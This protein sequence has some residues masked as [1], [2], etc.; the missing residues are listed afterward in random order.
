MRGKLHIKD[1][2]K[3]WVKRGKFGYRQKSRYCSV[4]IEKPK[5]Y[6]SPYVNDYDVWA[7]SKDYNKYNNWLWKAIFSPS[8]KTVLEKLLEIET[9][10]FDKELNG[11]VFKNPD[12]ISF[13]HDPIKIPFQHKDGKVYLDKKFFSVNEIR[14][15]KILILEPKEKL[16]RDPYPFTKPSKA[17]LEIEKYQKEEEFRKFP[18]LLNR[19]RR[20]WNKWKHV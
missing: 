10:T 5:V 11:W 20:R 14:T 16:Y 8:L 19:A 13:R 1:K 2:H 7:T 4:K 12:A 3:A 9:P 18:K 6:V 15:E 17:K